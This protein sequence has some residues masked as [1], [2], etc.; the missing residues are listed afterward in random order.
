MN[1]AVSKYFVVAD[2]VTGSILN[3]CHQLCKTKHM[4]IFTQYQCSL[5]HFLFYYKKLLGHLLKWWSEPVWHKWDVTLWM[6]LTKTKAQMYH[7]TLC[8]AFFHCT[9]FIWAMRS[10]N[11][12]KIKIHEKALRWRQTQ[13]YME[14]HQMYCY[15]T[16]ITYV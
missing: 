10:L 12:C 7:M 1:E 8:K 2:N 9:P 15:D 6:W 4:F 11:P 16:H 5:C 13:P 3:S 14:E